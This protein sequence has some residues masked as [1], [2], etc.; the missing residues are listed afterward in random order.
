MGSSDKFCLRWNDFEVNISSAF[1]EIRKDEDFFDVTLAS[2]D[3]HQIKAHKV[4]LSACSPFFRKVL[5]RNPH[6]SPLLYLKGIRYSDLVSILNFMYHG[7]VNVAQDE[8]NSFLAAAEELCVRGLTTGNDEMA[9]HHQARGSKVK[10]AFQSGPSSKRS[11]IADDRDEDG[12]GISRGVDVKTEPH[13]GMAGN[14]EDDG[15]DSSFR[16][17]GDNYDNYGENDGYDEEYEDT[18]DQGE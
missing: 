9:S 16:D 4:I 8:L 6:A 17:T 5:K 1:R 12:R 14:G 18:T 7:E 11:R 15:M 10:S 3:D 13:Q 2:E